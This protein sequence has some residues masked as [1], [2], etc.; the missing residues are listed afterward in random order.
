MGRSDKVMILDFLKLP[1]DAELFRVMAPDFVA[2]LIFKGGVAVYGAPI[3][4]W[5]VGLSWTEMESRCK[6]YGYSFDRI[7]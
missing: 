1:G 6:R 5:A 7:A 4:R 3:L 2:G